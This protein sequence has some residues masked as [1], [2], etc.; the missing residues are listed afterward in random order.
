MRSWI[1]EVLLVPL[2]SF[3]NSENAG[4]DKSRRV[5]SVRRLFSAMSSSF[6]ALKSSASDALTASSPS[7]WPMYSVLM[8][9]INPITRER[10][11]N[12]LSP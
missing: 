5:R 9:A 4:E 8:L 10:G 11:G 6:L 1:A 2:N 7:S 3:R 12:T